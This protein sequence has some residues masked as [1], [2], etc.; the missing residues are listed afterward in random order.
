MK[1][2]VWKHTFAER[3]TALAASKALTH[4]AVQAL[5]T[6]PPQAATKIVS[7]AKLFSS[8]LAQ[9]VTYDCLQLHGGYGFIEEYDICRQH[10]DV[11]LLPIGGGT[12]EVM[13][14]IIWKMTE[15]GA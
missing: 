10:R 5:N 14:E 11:R 13:K 6:L 15:L 1:L 4:Q 8:D 2:Q 3:L 12:S 9:K 7:Q